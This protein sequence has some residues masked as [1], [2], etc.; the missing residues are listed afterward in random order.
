[1]IIKLIAD[2]MAVFKNEMKFYA[3][4]KLGIFV[5]II[6]SENISCFCSKFFNAL[7]NNYNHAIR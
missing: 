1:M 4:E 5:L 6:N 3:K 7:Y 2:I